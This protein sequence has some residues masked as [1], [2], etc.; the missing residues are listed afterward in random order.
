MYTAIDLTRWQIALDS[1]QVLKPGTLA[2]MR[3]PSELADGTRIEYGLGTRLGSFL[4]HRV[5]GHTG[6]GG[7][8]TTVLEDFPD[9][10]LMIAVLINTEGAGANRCRGRH[11]TSGVRGFR[12]ATARSAGAG[13]RA[14]G[15]RGNV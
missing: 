7:G 14:G 8:F 3:R 11:R 1:G 10:R 12:S 13:A 15:H 2:L 9:D 5:V 6:S 4:G